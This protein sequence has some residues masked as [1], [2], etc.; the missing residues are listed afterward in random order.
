MQYL[1]ILALLLFSLPA[2]A[3]IESYE[4]ASPQQEQTYQQLIQQL[5]CPQCQNNNIADSNATIAN[6]MRA[7]VHELLQ[8]GQNKDEIV[9]YM[10]Q[11]YG[12]FVTYDPP[13]TA[14]TLLLWLIPAGLL[15]L[16]VIVL[17]RRKPHLTAE[18]PAT[19]AVNADQQRLDQQRLE[20]ILNS[21]KEKK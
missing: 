9:D 17:F 8:Q 15:L 20:A 2:F 16:G 4:F 13:L 12:N 18:K 11:R 21:D 10:V 5:R 19:S 1:K 3:V 6:D 14:S 7:K